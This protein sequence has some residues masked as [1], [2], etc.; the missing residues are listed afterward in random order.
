M[1]YD[2]QPGGLRHVPIARSTAVVKAIWPLR[3]LHLARLP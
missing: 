3:A 1:R 2:A